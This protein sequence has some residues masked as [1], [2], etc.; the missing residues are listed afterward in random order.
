[1]KRLRRDLDNVKHGDAHWWCWWSWA[2]LVCS[3][4]ILSA[5]EFFSDRK[6]VPCSCNVHEMTRWRTRSLIKA[7]HLFV[8][9]PRSLWRVV[10]TERLSRSLQCVYGEK[11]LLITASM[12]RDPQRRSRALPPLSSPWCWS[13]FLCGENGGARVQACRHW[14]RCRA[15]VV[16]E[17]EV[18]L[19]S[20]FFLK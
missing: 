20:P 15:S 12:S 13:C 8:I 10:W 9:T 6:L 2:E 19:L 4:S 11:L 5:D 17:M 1:M 3:S 7:W 14:E 16:D 18:S